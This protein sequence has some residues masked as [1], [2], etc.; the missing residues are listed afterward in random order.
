MTPNKSWYEFTN[1]AEVDSPAL[2]IYPDRAEE[3]VRRMIAIAGEPERLCPHVKTHKLAEL[4]RMQMALGITKFKCATIAEAE[5]VASC[6]AADV[7]LAHQ[8]VGPKVQRLIQL[9]KKFPQTSF[10]TIADDESAVRALSQAATQAGVQ[11]KVLLDL[12]CGMH[13]SGIAP[14]PKA[15][16]LYRLMASL[17]GLE[18]QGFH[19]Y[20]GHIDDKD[21]ALRTKNCDEAFAAVTTLRRELSDLPVP[22]IIAGGTPTFPIHARR[23]GVECSPGTSIFWDL[24]YGNQCPDLDFLNAA[25]VLTRVISKPGNNRLCLDLGHKAIAAEKPHPRVQFLNLPDAQA[26]TH[27]EEHLVVETSRADEFQV[28][29]VLYG[30]PRHVCPTVAL[31]AEAVVIRNDRAE[32]RW[33]IAA[34]DRKLSV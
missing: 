31:H 1:V 16:A 8:P 28:G 6:G 2:L 20:D 13:R 32:E 18:A 23:P 29:D 17:P 12:D 25:L 7:V 26:V 15:A 30:I 34:R 9:I 4:V 19:A 33:K 21:V 24:G 27:S 3:N 22:R 14:D 11:I 5:M 10:A